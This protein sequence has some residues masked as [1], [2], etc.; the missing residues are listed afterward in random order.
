MC[1]VYNCTALNLCGEMLATTT[2]TDDKE[3]ITFLKAE[4]TDAC[5]GE[6]E[7]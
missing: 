5:H 2:T 7:S 3:T 6:E 4:S 1:S